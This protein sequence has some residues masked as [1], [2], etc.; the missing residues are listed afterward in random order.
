M[1]IFIRLLL[2]SV[3][4]ELLSF[5]SLTSFRNLSTQLQT[6]TQIGHPQQIIIGFRDEIR[7]RLCLGKF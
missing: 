3:Q 7:S 2:R 5:S 6:K 1:R 4:P